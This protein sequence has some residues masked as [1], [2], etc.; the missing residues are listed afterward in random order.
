[1]IENQKI[2]VYGMMC[3]HCENTVAT[4][5]NKLPGVKDAAASF[6]DEVVSFTLDTDKST[7]ADV[8]AVILDNDYS[9]EPPEVKELR[10]GAPREDDVTLEF[11]QPEAAPDLEFELEP[12]PELELESG[13]DN[14]S[15]ISF[16]IE[17]MT[18][19][20]CSLAIEK[21]FKRTKGVR[22]TSINL[23]LNKGFVTYDPRVLD[24]AGILDV[25][26]QA[27]YRATLDKAGGQAAAA[28]ERF[29]FFF[30]LGLTV[31]MVLIM[32]LGPFGMA[33]T[34]SILFVL[35]TLV[36][37]VSGR[38]FYE[39]AYYSL[40]N[41]VANM[42]VLISLG[43]SA[44]YFYSVFSLFFIDAAK[45]VFF[46]SS[47]MLITFIMIG[48]MLEANAKG[49]TGQALKELLALNPDQAR[50]VRA[51]LEEMIHPS[52]VE[53]G[54]VV[55]VLAG[56]KIPVDGEVLEGETQVDESM[57]T[58]E[59]FPV[60]KVPGDKVIGATI[61]QS[62][63][64]R[65]KTTKTGNDT[66]LAGIVKMV[67]DAQADKAPIQRL[68]D[69][70]SNVFVPIVVAVAL[71]TFFYWYFMGALGADADTTPFLFSF[72][73]MIAVLVIACPCALGLATP[74][75]IMVGTGVGLN[76]GILF[77]K[78]S[79]LENI[80]HLDVV[81]FDKT[82]TITRGKPEV[83]DVFPAEGVTRD[84]F[85]K[86]VVSAEVNSSH[87]LAASVVA[88]ARQSGFEPEKTTGAREISGFGVQ[89]LLNGK[90][91]KAGNL[92]L[93][94]GVD[95]T[96][97]MESKGKMLAEQ[98]K[99]TVYIALDNRMV[100]ILSLSDMIKPD[101]KEAVERLHR[102][103]I[104]TALVSGD[105][106]TS[107]LAVAKQ[108][109]IDEVEAEVLPQDKINTVKKWQA[110]GLKV[111]MVGDGINDAPALA[112]ADIGIAIGSGTD[113][114]KETGDVILVKNSLLD[115]ERAIRLGKKSL[116]T[117]KMNFF[118]AF[119]YNLLMIPIAAGV[120]YPGYGL[121]LKPEFASIAMWMSSLSVVG[122]SLLLKRFEKKLMD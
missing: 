56:E 74:T 99:T 121:T 41:R 91:L 15:D 47:A 57:L 43:I 22:T 75:A 35:A 61:N 59:S 79:V 84:D 11:S 7:L 8:E 88:F 78:G 82:G 77:K 118:W 96:P 62:G 3:S 52:L 14:F 73:R 70:I 101:S 105:N 60:H 33:V 112:Q 1:M 18:C 90:E 113:V 69:T 65:V 95:I 27:G 17:G 40:K 48:K 55:K 2:K 31:P 36:Q 110:K 100:G 19:A 20:N 44:A 87:P 115:V 53:K 97:E 109:G 106:L 39:G 30:A 34:N 5:L 81:L 25:V 122:N 102:A 94:K 85:L 21:A 32:H 10:E 51:G 71:A 67:E 86:L 37:F 114:A 16:N 64:I 66:V 4:E 26:K 103:G 29:R 120:L 107:A 6:E 93:V 13:Q 80:S 45:P 28:R 42:D 9:L 117:I 89:C 38:A 76:R 104:R 50:V 116:K 24:D 54:D 12:G 92:K 72:E 49:K 58:G 68:A 119:F 111:A 46:D 23:P 63:T 108:V 98:G 83:S